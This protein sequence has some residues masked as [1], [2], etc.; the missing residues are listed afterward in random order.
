MVTYMNK[1][2][3]SILI[4]SVCFLISVSFFGCSSQKV[5]NNNAE[6]EAQYYEYAQQCIEEGNVEEA[7]KALEEGIAA[8][9]SEK[10]QQLLDEINDGKNSEKTENI[11]EPD[12][13]EIPNTS[14]KELR[15]KSYYNE[16]YGFCVEYPDYFITQQQSGNGDGC[17][18][19]S[20]DGEFVM[21]VWGSYIVTVDGEPTVDNLYNYYLNYL[22]YV[23]TY[24]FKNS[25]F[26]VFSG[27]VGG[28]VIYEKHI[29]KSDGTENVLLLEY[30]ATR[31]SE[32]DDIVTHISKSMVTGVG[33]DSYV[34]E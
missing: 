20:S 22:D 34:A 26:F 24:E 14:K 8:T 21:K 29:V 3:K 31:E 10:L 15:Y 9:G 23:P 27:N 18:F 28:K 5:Q 33:Y 30:S 13:E 25:K 2:Y 32:F 1:V 6:V 4:L 12:N 19:A 7:I 17:V 16:R 11:E